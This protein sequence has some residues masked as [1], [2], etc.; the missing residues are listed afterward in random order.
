MT[1]CIRCRQKKKRCDQKLPVSVLKYGGLL[2]A[3]PEVPELSDVLCRDA[4]C[5]RLPGLS[6]LDMMP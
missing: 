2:R 6:A 4:A 5:A 1:A 3:G